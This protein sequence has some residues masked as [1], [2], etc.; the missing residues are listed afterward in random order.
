KGKKEGSMTLPAWFS[1]EVS[2]ALI[3]Q[4]VHVLNKR[5]RIRRAHVKE[6]AEVRGGGRKPWRQKGTGRARHASIRSP[7]WTGGGVTFGPRSRKETIGHI[8][9]T[10]K[11]AALRGVLRSHAGADS[12]MVVRLPQESPKKT[13]EAASWFNEARAITFIIGANYSQ[14]QRVMRNI[15]RIRIFSADNVTVKDMAEATYLW[16]DE[17]ALPTLEKR[18]TP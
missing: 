1:E 11:R 12:L 17:S 6:R 5:Q 8:P 13:A 18:S 16:I 14:W 4:V 3:A 15:P 7:L 9:V 10:E 2:P